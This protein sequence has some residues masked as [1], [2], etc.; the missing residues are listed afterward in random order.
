L[1]EN[2]WPAN[3]S[4]FSVVLE[5]TNDQNT[6]ALCI[7]GFAH[8]IK[9][10]GYFNMKDERDAFVASL[11]KFASVSSDQRIK[12]KNILVIRQI[13]ELATYQG[14]YLGESWFFVLECI[15]RLEE[16][17]QVGH[18]NILDSDFFE[19]NSNQPA[20][21]KMS[22]A[23]RAMHEQNRQ[24]NCELVVQSIEMS[25]IDQIFQSSLN[26]DQ[27]AIIQFIENLCK[28]SRQELVDAVNPRKFS[29]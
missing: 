12:N 28:V 19:T 17:I 13:L 29:L 27:D 20:N 3:L 15:S 21:K 11:S 18:G 25:Q 6:A 2:I 24:A 22:Q 10:C 26:L 16:M 9:I 7:E 8:S 4:T 14:N 1:F 5:K 23:S